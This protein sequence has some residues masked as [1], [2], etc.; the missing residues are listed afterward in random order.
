[1]LEIYKSSYTYNNVYL[2]VCI[3]YVFSIVHVKLMH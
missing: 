2:C 1:M 3:L